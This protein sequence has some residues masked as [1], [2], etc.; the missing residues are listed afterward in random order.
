MATR[1]AVISI[2][3]SNTNHVEELNRILTN[4][5][6][7]IIGRMGVPYREKGVNLISVVMDAPQD[8]IN[9]MTGKIG[10]LQGI[11]SKTLFSPLVT[12]TQKGA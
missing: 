7:Y 1:V 5:N 3:V 9:T 4:Y 11:T 6:S 2:I 12:E 8:M 10:R